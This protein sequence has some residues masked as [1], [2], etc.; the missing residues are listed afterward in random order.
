MSF[1]M[2]I[3]NIQVTTVTVTLMLAE[4]VAGSGSSW[5]EELEGI[6]T[7]TLLSC[8]SHPGGLKLLRLRL[9]SSNDKDLPLP[10]VASTPSIFYKQD[11]DIM[12]CTCVPYF[13]CKNG[14]M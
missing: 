1:A 7:L 8:T 2:Y 12:Q 14:Y 9:M 3:A 4:L 5:T 6:S 11:N 13:L 10:V